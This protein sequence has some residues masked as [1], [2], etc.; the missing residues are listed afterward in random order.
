LVLVPT[1]FHTVALEEF[2]NKHQQLIERDIVVG[3]LTG[4]GSVEDHCLPGAQQAAVLNEFRKGKL[5]F[6][7]N[8]TVYSILYLRHENYTRCNR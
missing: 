3:H 6:Q 7:R 4:Q 8:H 1:K 5:K 2:L